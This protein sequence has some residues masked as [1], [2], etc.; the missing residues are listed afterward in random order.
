MPSNRHIAQALDILAD[1][2]EL[3]GANIYKTIAH[4]KAARRVAESNFSIKEMADACTLT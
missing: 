3:D 4:R 1:M 2:M